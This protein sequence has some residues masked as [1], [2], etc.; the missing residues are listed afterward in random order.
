MLVEFYCT[1]NR[2]DKHFCQLLN[3]HATNGVR[4]TEIHTANP[5]VLEGSTVMFVMAAEKLQMY[6]SPG[7][8]QFN[9]D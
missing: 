5:L 2:W 8:D 1:L 4:Q 7:I 6:K 9:H 3:V